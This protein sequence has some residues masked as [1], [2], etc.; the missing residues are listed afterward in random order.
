MARDLLGQPMQR[1]GLLGA[2][3]GRAGRTVEG[4]D[5]DPV[6]Q[7]DAAQLADGLLPRQ[8]VAGGSAQGFREGV[9]LL[10][11]EALGDRLGGKK[12]AEP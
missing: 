6:R 2:R 8:G 7:A 10:A 4:R 12:G 9:G 1:Q 11:K 5:G 3:V